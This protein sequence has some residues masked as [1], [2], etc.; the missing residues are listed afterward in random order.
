[1][2]TP[3]P[4]AR[5]SGVLLI[6]LG[7]LA[8]GACAGVKPAAKVTA[9]QP[10]FT[11]PVFR[12][13]T[14]ATLAQRYNVPAD[15]LLAL[16]PTKRNKRLAAG[17]IR[18]P[19]S[20]R[21]G[22]APLPVPISVAATASRPVQAPARPAAIEA[23]A[24]KPLPTPSARSART[25]ASTR[26][27]PAASAAA[28]EP[29]P[30][31]AV[32]E[33]EPEPVAEM[34]WSDLITGPEPDSAAPDGDPRFLWPIQGE[35][36][37]PFGERPGGGRNDGINISA[38]RGAPIRAA[39]AGQVSYVGNELKGYGNLILIRHENGFI[40]AYAHADGVEVRRGQ[41]VQRGEVIGSAG[42]TGDVPQP[43]LHFELRRGTKPVDPA[44]YLVAR[45]TG[46]RK[47]FA[48]GS[49]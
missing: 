46:L 37:S 34:S 31:P 1:M 5:R 9:A 16:N 18:V 43:Q 45:K 24:L 39:D 38:K 32:A 22:S 47:L 30:A 26:V 19:S 27:A 28:V 8:L 17:W 4:L 29:S 12:G 20:A 36:I 7:A 25:A 42:D 6:A 33:P 35:V 15:D 44:L 10:F 23:R 40:S 41:R 3:S 48:E 49:R 14:I 11:A 2:A 21:P 13:D